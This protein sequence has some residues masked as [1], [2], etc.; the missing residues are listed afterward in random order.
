VSAL[1]PIKD[2]FENSRNPRI[3]ARKKLHDAKALWMACVARHF[4]GSQVGAHR[5]N[6]HGGRRVRF[7]FKP[8]RT[9]SGLTARQQ[10]RKTKG[11]VSI[12]H[13]GVVSKKVRADS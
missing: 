3:R 13:I 2:I 4:S 1:P 8:P 12:I 6:Y 11:F 9:P 5:L 7:V 10:A